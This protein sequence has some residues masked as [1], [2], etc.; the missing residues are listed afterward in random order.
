MNQA[1]DYCV[2]EISNIM[3][4]TRF[5]YKAKIYSGDNL[6]TVEKQ[7]EENLQSNH[8][9]IYFTQ[10]DIMTRICR[11]TSYT[12]LTRTFNA[13][14]ITLSIERCDQREAANALTLIN[15]ARTLEGATNQNAAFFK[16][17]DQN[18]DFLKMQHSD[19]WH[20]L[21]SESCI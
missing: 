20:L 16:A 17:S 1:E 19:W 12:T 13:H 10:D 7:L 9:G 6:E 11:Y 15:R 18:V 5:S 4:S 3:R 14:E 2:I 21:I 8:D